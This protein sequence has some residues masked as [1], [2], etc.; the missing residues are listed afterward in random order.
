MTDLTVGY[1]DALLKAAR[2]EN[3]VPIVSEEMQYLAREFSQN[4]RVFYAPVFS[5]REQLAT[6]EYILNGHFHPLTKRFMCL[7]ASM[8]RLGGIVKITD[9]FVELV[10]KEMRKID[11]Y[12]TAYDELLPD[13]ESDLIQT[14]CG[15]GLFDSQYLPNIEIHTAVDKDLLGG[16]IAECDGISWDCSLKTRLLEASKVIRKG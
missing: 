14:A 3:A 12:I 6:V 7:L 10:T 8:R 4:A 16:F 15:K 5:V 1:A 9:A 2:H 13:L 11:V